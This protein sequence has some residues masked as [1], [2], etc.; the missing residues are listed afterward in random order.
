MAP[1]F[2][3]MFVCALWFP[4]HK[5]ACFLGSG[6]LFNSGQ[7]RFAY[8][9]DKPFMTTEKHGTNPKPTAIEPGKRKERVGY[10]EHCWATSRTK[11]KCLLHLGFFKERWSCNPF[12]DACAASPHYRAHWFAPFGCN[13]Q[14]LADRSHRW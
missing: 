3:D 10:W 5:K 4:E 14:L 12:A 2:A 13:G 7:T 9:P 1:A 11:N 8:S 6:M